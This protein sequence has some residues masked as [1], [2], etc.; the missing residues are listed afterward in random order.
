MLFDS[1]KKEYN[2]LIIL[3]ENSL[4][5]I[6]QINT[7]GKI[8]LNNQFVNERLNSNIDDKKTNSVI[9]NY[10]LNSSQ[11]KII[12]DTR[13]RKIS[14]VQGLPSTGKTTTNIVFENNTHIKF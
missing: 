2:A 9:E 5:P 13:N 14:L 7:D 1:I 6:C 8:K 4:L 3:T 10:S 11:A 12:R